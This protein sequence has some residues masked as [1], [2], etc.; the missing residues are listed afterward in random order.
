[1]P[2]ESPEQMVPR[3]CGGVINLDL[4]DNTHV[5]D[6]HSLAQVPQIHDTM[7]QA[8]L[9]STCIDLELD[10]QK[11]SS[12]KGRLGAITD[13]WNIKISEDLLVRAVVAWLPELL[14]ASA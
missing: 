10:G 14:D 1:M 12:R 4:G 7:E 5:T 9:G 13:L 3:L 11:E 8:S 2:L 6:L